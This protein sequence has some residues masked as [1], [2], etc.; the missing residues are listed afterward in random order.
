MIFAHL[1]RP[2]HTKEKKGNKPVKSGLFV[3]FPLKKCQYLSM[4]A[5]NYQ[6]NT[7]LWT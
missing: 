5:R 6:H 4:L 1:K 3:H 2:G 7:G